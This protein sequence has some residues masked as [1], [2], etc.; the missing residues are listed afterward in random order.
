MYQ[1]SLYQ[2]S[3]SFFLSAS[4]FFSYF[5]FAVEHHLLLCDNHTP[6]PPRNCFNRAALFTC[7]T[8]LLHF[9]HS[10]SPFIHEFSSHLLL[11]HLSLLGLHCSALLC[12]ALP[13]N[14]GNSELNTEVVNF[15]ITQLWT[16]AAKESLKISIT[17]GRSCSH[18]AG[19]HKWNWGSHD[20]WPLG[21]IWP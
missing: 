12:S 14:E 17:I 21:L 10:T 15:L 3:P 19:L 6:P 2:C 8:S 5:A 13:G 7:L 4:S 16:A 1:F 9:R 18:A 11:L 20:L